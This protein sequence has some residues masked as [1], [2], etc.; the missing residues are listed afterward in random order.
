MAKKE[1]ISLRDLGHQLAEAEAAHPQGGF[2]HVVLSPEGRQFS[3]HRS[4]A[5]ANAVAARH[6]GATVAPYVSIESTYWNTGEP[7][8]D[9]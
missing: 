6:K 7:R 8:Y 2:T 4:E 9:H 3:I 1:R 5:D